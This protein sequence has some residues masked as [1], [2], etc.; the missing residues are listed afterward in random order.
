MNKNMGATD[1]IIR[2]VIA[3]G[4]ATLYFSNLISGTIAIIAIAVAIVFLLTSVLSIC[5]LY[6]IFGITT[7]KVPK[8]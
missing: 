4:L 6:S 3:L 2:V 8:K 1:K 7:C 5:P